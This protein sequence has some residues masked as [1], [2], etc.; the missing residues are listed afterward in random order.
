MA[1]ARA[2]YAAVTAAAGPL[3]VRYVTKA[4]PHPALLGALAAD[5]AAFAVTTERELD[6]L[7]TQGVAGA[8]IA[9]VTPGPPA[10]LLRR[11]RAAGVGHLTVDT[12][13]E[14][15][16]TAALAPGASVLVALRC[17]PAGRL[18]YPA[19]PLGASLE[20]LDALAA[21][22][23][24]LPVQLAGVAV[25]VG[26][27]C[28]RLAPWRAAVA[29]AGAAW[30]RL[31]AAGGAPRVLS[32][33][34]GLPVRY[35]QAVPTP[36]TICRTLRAALAAHFPTPP[37]EVWLEPGRYVAAGAGVLVATVVHREARAGW[38]PRLTLDV[39][40]YAGL[41]EAGL[42]IRY[43][44]WV[45]EAEG[46]GSA[47]PR[48]DSPARLERCVLLGPGGAVD[49]VDPAARL[50]RLTPGDRLCFL[51]AGAYTTCQ[52]A[53][54]VPAA[55]PLVRVDARAAPPARRPPA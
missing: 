40:R 10:S 13:W 24:G 47:G 4:N 25:H 20:A 37:A 53:Y 27:Q 48:R 41:P 19:A 9:C 21:A 7:L 5:G 39:G 38:R 33:G 31:Q 50:P 8:R 42:G 15:Q 23:H 32:L 1:Q 46:A 18:R 45:P 29:L 6:A 43:P 14:L 12:V 30:Q 36:A 54:P 55:G 17:S 11:C 44:Y 28:E 49:V 51:R 16:K 26:S 22:A 34:G 2:D 3:R 35:R 52:A